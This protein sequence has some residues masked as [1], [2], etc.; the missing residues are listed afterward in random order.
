MANLVD[1]FGLTPISK[2]IGEDDE[3]TAQLKELH[4]KGRAYLRGFKWCKS[5]TEE[6]FGAGVAD[7]VAAFLFRI[8]PTSSDVD[9]L[10]WVIVGDIPSA[11]LVVD[12]A[13]TPAAALKMYIELRREW[14][15]AI[16]GSETIKELTPVDAKPILENALDLERRLEFL[17]QRILP[18]FSQQKQGMQ[19]KPALGFILSRGCRYTRVFYPA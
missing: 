9:S 19:L 3:E 7:I 6:Y 8:V 15:N 5:V 12:E 1:L 16:K 18:Q 10:I 14:V 13:K 4:L 17:E 11:Y 2:M